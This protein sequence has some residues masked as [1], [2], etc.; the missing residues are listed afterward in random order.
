[1]PEEPRS[2]DFIEFMNGWCKKMG[3]Q[4]ICEYVENEE[5]QQIMTEIGVAYSQGYYFSK[6][7]EWEE[8]RQVS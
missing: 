5:I 4:L 6:P 3:K 7:H 8:E 2:R 1:M